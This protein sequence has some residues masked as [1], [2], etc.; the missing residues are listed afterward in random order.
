MSKIRDRFDTLEVEADASR[1]LRHLWNA[2][3]MLL[4]ALNLPT[5]LQHKYYGSLLLKNRSD[6]LRSD[7]DQ[8]SESLRQ[9]VC[10][11]FH[12]IIAALM[13]DFKVLEDAELQKT[14]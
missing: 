8:V 13:S 5:G 10:R 9:V 12:S 14:G 1:E 11:T 6:F 4:F 2:P 7:L 3:A